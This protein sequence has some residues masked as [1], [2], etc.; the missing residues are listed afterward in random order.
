MLGLSGMGGIGKTT[1]ASALYNHLQPAFTDAS[2]FLEEVRSQS[3]DGILRSQ[4]HLL[5]TLT[6]AAI[7]AHDTG[8]GAAGDLT[9]HALHC[10][11]GNSRA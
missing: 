6:G 10:F 11:H 9:C 1:L 2:C 8:E 4:L 7:K 3:R 5:K